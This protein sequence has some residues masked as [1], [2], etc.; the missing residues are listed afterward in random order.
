MIKTLTI[1][2]LEIQI[3]YTLH[4]KGVYFLELYL[5]RQS[6]NIA[7]LVELYLLA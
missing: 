6:W 7:P 4:L 5:K 1:K 2:I 3:Q